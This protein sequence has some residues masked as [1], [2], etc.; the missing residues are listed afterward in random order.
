MPR[1][2]P[3]VDAPVLVLVNGPPAAGKTTLARALAHSLRRPLLSKDDLKESLFDSFGTG[4][5]AWSRRVGSATFDLLYLLVEREVEADRSVVVEA[6]FDPDHAC[7]RLAE[8]RSRHPFRLVEVHL[9]ASDDVL[10]E[11]FLT[12]AAGGR[13]HAGH[14]DDVVAAELASG[15][16]RGRWAPLPCADDLVEVDATTLGD[17]TTA[18]ALDALTQALNQPPRDARPAVT[19]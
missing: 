7:A 9:G 18:R 11:R 6:N 5:R 12:R 8:L 16:H 3:A 2:T 4:D 15:A 13:R 1:A 14:L 19:R 10:R 17:A